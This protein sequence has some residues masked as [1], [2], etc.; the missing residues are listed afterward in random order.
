M[1]KK[2]NSKKRTEDNNKTH[3][4]YSC[5]PRP[6]YV[7]TNSLT[8]LPGAPA[9]MLQEKRKK[10]R[11]ARQA[12]HRKKSNNHYF[13]LPPFVA[14]GRLDCALPA[15]SAAG[16]LRLPALATHVLQMRRFSLSSSTTL[17]QVPYSRPPHPPWQPWR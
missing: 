5:N 14:F 15:L 7:G 17:P 9:W 3:Y 16:A 11:Q 13:L 6:H 10:K 12:A 4:N 1:K 2:N 8:C